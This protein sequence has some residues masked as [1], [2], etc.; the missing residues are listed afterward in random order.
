LNGG[1]TLSMT[2]EVMLEKE[3]DWSLSARIVV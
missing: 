1:R 3:I 2:S